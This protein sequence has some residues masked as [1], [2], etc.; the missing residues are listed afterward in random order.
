MKT[1]EKISSKGQ[2]ILCLCMDVSKTQVKSLIMKKDFNIKYLYET[3]KVG[4]K[5]TACLA[6]LELIIMVGFSF[7]IK[8]FLDNKT[9]K[10]YYEFITDSRYDS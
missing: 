4:S 3:L 1:K 10:Y 5:C 8:K 6:D 9:R 7:F 2:D